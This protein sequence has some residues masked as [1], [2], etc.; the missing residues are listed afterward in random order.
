MKNKVFYRGVVLNICVCIV[1]LTAFSYLLIQCYCNSKTPHRTTPYSRKTLCEEEYIEDLKLLESQNF[2]NLDDRKKLHC[3][4]TLVD[5]ES[6]K[7]GLPYYVKVKIG[8]LPETIAGRYSDKDESIII[9]RKAFHSYSSRE[10]VKI[11]YHEWHHHLTHILSDAYKSLPKIYSN[12][13][14]F[15][16]YRIYA[17]EYD[18]YISANQ[19][20]DL[21][22]LQSVESDARRYAELQTDGLFKYLNKLN[23]NNN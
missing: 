1:L 12:L 9:D 2:N 18:N 11:T 4:Q 10:L 13:E 22:Y 16:Q 23:E 6:N 15:S 7:A 17:F 14:A 20:D 19:D 5:I 21:Y 8:D 3:L